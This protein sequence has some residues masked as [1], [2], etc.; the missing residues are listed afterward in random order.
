[1]LKEALL[2][3]NLKKIKEKV[4]NTIFYLELKSKGYSI[5]NINEK[6]ILKDI[7]F[8]NKMSAYYESANKKLL[9]N[10]VV[11]PYIYILK[12]KQAIIFQDYTLANKLICHLKSILSTHNSIEK[13]QLL[14]YVSYLELHQESLS[15][16]NEADI[17]H[18]QYHNSIE[19]YQQQQKEFNNKMQQLN[20]TDDVNSIEGLELS[21]NHLEKFV[22]MI[23]LLVK[24]DNCTILEEDLKSEGKYILNK[25]N[26]LIERNSSNQSTFSN[27]FLQCL[28]LIEKLR[29]SFYIEEPS[30]ELFKLNH[31]LC[32]KI[33]SLTI[34]DPIGY[35]S[36]EFLSDEVKAHSF[37]KSQP[38][39]QK[40]LY[41][42]SIEIYLDNSS[43]AYFKMKQY[44]NFCA[45]NKDERLK[46]IP[47][48]DSDASTVNKL[49]Q[50]EEKKNE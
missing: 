40:F 13:S 30:N 1:M 38:A 15:W 26:V 25:I 2:I 44:S 17:I 27:Q 41:S 8:I 16:C 37:F 32:K 49:V 47:V 5:K 29:L 10:I 36:G 11:E 20:D 43:K 21:K 46:I 42:F 18:T 35:I 22:D 28:L 33:I 12:I 6:D 50:T 4:Y 9:N 39:F 24:K 14:L 45:S 7:S 3:N 23:S 48:G 19:S 31:L 34:N